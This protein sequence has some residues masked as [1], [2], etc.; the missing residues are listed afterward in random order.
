MN[1]FRDYG[2][3]D[4]LIGK[5]IMPSSE[6]LVEILVFTTYIDVKI[7]TYRITSLLLLGMTLFVPC[8]NRQMADKTKSWFTSE[9]KIVSAN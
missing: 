3:W 8:R 4:I 5:A 1:N 6:K 2:L 7:R 9:C